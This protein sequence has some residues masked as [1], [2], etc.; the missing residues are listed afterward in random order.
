MQQY[1]ELA[2]D[3]RASIAN[4]KKRHCKLGPTLKLR[5]GEAVAWSFLLGC[6][7][8]QLRPNHKRLAHDIQDMVR[9]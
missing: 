7:H 5:R 3:A 8:R 2:K 6:V 1:A 4:I 9:F